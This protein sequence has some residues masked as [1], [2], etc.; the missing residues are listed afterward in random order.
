MTTKE[1]RLHF[2]A[3]RYSH[4]HHEPKSECHLL[5]L[6]KGSSIGEGH[7]YKMNIFAFFWLYA[8]IM[9]N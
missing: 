8:R 4:R 2:I 7:I 9:P 5:N 6:Y 3:F 1:T